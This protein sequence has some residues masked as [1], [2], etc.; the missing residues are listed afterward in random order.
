MYTNHSICATCVTKLDQANFE[1][2][3]IMAVSSHKSEST[4]KTY[5]KKCLECKKREM[6]E[7]LTES[8]GQKCP[9]PGPSYTCL[10]L[11]NVDLSEVNAEELIQSVLKE[12]APNKPLQEVVV[13][14]KQ[15]VSNVPTGQIQSPLPGLIPTAMNVQNTVNNNKHLTM[16]MMYFPQSNVTIN[17]NY[18]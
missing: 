14:P 18:N 3:H 11:L 9:Y 13:A 5:A 16:P 1:S 10:D 6:S 8:M 7:T 2:C 17:Y 15:P 4:V 12:T